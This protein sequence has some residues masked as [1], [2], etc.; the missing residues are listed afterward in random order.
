MRGVEPRGSTAVEA[1]GTLSD[2]EATDTRFRAAA[3]RLVPGRGRYQEDSF[4]LSAPVG[5]IALA[6]GRG[7]GRPDIDDF[8]SIDGDLCI[9]RRPRRPVAV[10]Q[11]LWISDSLI[12]PSRVHREPER[13]HRR[14]VLSTLRPHG[15]EGELW[16]GGRSRPIKVQRVLVHSGRDHS[17]YDP[18]AQVKDLEGEPGAAIPLGEG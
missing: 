14:H 18:V 1:T 12:V 6:E 11:L 10:R 5:P 16:R 13:V 3:P 4:Q 2:A 15:A 9:I 17:G 8:D 7:L